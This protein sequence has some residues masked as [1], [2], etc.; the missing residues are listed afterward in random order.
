MD[1]YWPVRNWVSG[2][3]VRDR[4]ASKASSVFT[5][6]PHHSHYCLSSASWWIQHYGEL[7]NYFNIYHNV[8]II[9]TKCTISLTHLN[10]LETIPL[11]P[12]VHGK[13][14]FPK[15]GPCCQKGWGL[16]LYILRIRFSLRKFKETKMI[17][18]RRI[19]SMVTQKVSRVKQVKFHQPWEKYITNSCVSLCFLLL[20]IRPPLLFSW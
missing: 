17:L 20:V 5:S 12:P 4:W 14:V 19:C 15:T 2:Q 7:Y 8:I 3:E 18:Y 13:I 10:R 9:E 1:L 16:L 11:S 6:S